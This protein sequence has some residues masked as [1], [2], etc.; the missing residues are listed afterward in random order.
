MTSSPVS[1]FVNRM[2][3]HT[4]IG[5]MQD[6]R[7]IHAEW[8]R[9]TE[10]DRPGQVFVGKVNR[11]VPALKAAFVDLGGER[12]AFLNQSDL[13]IG[14]LPDRRTGIED[15]LKEGR[16]LVVQIKKSGYRDKLPQVTARV[17][18]P[19]LLLVGLWQERG[20]HYAK[21]YQGE[22]LGQEA[23]HGLMDSEERPMGWLIR[24]AASQVP[25]KRLVQEAAYHLERAEQARSAL[26]RGQLGPVLQVFSDLE[27]LFH[28]WKYGVRHCF[29]DDE[30]LFQAR[31][32]LAEA[33]FPALLPVFSLHADVHPLF[34]VYRVQSEWEQLSSPRVWLPSGGYLD[35]LPSEALTTVDVNSG[36]NLRRRGGLSNAMRT[37][38][39]A[40]VEVAR[41]VRLRQLSGL[42]VVDFV[43]VA[44]TEAKT[45]DRAL[46]DGFASDSA[47]IDLL[48]INR[49]GL[50]VI[51]RERTNPDHFGRL[52]ETCRACQGTGM[53][54]K[55]V[56]VAVE[57]QHQLLRQLPG[58]EGERVLVS[59]GAR[60]ARFFERHPAWLNALA[61]SYNIPISVVSAPLAK[62]L[63]FDIQLGA[64]EP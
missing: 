28:F 32:S 48:P 21:G 47:K 20:I 50:A 3:G 22:D 12:T 10:H 17:S 6:D 42:V 37:N 39:E 64:T 57:V 62:P 13:P 59:C 61:E 52:H 24:S 54:P 33:H 4:R 36:K 15:V 63:E 38:L 9:N 31:R 11:V 2:P 40:A 18:S 56:A 19:G 45:V 46:A 34:D 7:L 25:G 29:F 44:R 41:Q 14:M 60:L 26:A 1:L 5:V 35:F 49:F 43:N 8:I 23:N 53:Q 51:S 30:G 27:C 58:L 55:P 16:L